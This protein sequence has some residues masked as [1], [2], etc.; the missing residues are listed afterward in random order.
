MEKKL[1]QSNG[2]EVIEMT[3]TYKKYLFKDE[4]ELEKDKLQAQIDLIDED[5][6]LFT[7]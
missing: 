6:A 3:E 2:K 4:L 7:K 1:I 5:L